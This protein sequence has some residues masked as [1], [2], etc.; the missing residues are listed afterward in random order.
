MTV[1]DMA[2]IL[3][4]NNCCSEEIIQ[5]VTNIDGY[6]RETM[7]DILYATTGYRYFDSFL[8]DLE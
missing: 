3:L 7:E 6:S 2:E 8:E 5:V 4:D 1:E